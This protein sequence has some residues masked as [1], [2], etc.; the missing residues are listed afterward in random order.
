MASREQEAD[1][2][3]SLHKLLAPFRLPYLFIDGLSR[4]TSMH[5]RLGFISSMP[6]ADGIVT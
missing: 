3:L 6:Y 1:Y 4:G 2:T 5:I